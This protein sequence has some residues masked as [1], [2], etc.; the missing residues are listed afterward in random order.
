L[1]LLTGATGYV[2]GR[3]LQALEDSGRRVRCLVLPSQSLRS[4]LS[5]KAE[6]VTGD[7]LDA[8]SLRT[9]MQGV[10]T[11]YYLIYRAALDGPFEDDTRRAAVTFAAAARQ[12]GVRR[13]IYLGGLSGGGK[14][15][16][17]LCGSREIGAILRESG[18]VVIEFCTSVIV[19]SG[20]LSFEMIRTIVEKHPVMTTPRWTWTRTR[21]IAIEDVVAYLLA[22]LDTDIRESAIFEIGGADQVS[23]R[24]L[25]REYAHQRGLKRFLIP[26]P[27]LA[28]RL[29]IL[30]LSLVTPLY[31]RVG[32]E[33]VATLCKP[34]VLDNSR[35]LE[36]FPV[37]PYGYREAI[38]RALRNEGRPAAPTRWSDALNPLSGMPASEARFGPRIVDARSLHVPHP[39]A[40][41][42]Q[43]I[44]RI[45]GNT[46]WYYA[47]LLWRL[48]GLLD[49]MLGGVG[50]KRGRRDPEELCVGDTVDFWRVVAFERGRLLRL[51]AEMKVPGRAW[52]QFELEDNGRGSIIQQT[53]IFDP[54]GIPGLLYWYILSPAHGLIF[55]GMLRGIARAIPLRGDAQTARG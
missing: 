28:P 34:T 23:F 22:A 35:A 15:S 26:V 24:D 30:W 32:Q 12:A 19:G 51:A 5:S 38:G 52:L 54:V 4:N 40:L 46:G 53:A 55:P 3:L 47:N 44:E 7:V 17:Q 20:S 50:A 8:G 33:L 45:G 27:M 36:D 9:A 11:A 43:P 1:I 2:G 41:A 10:D 42:F 49:A 21:P 18:A 6:A 37:R 13:I 29:T 39:S 14:Y 25:L 48:R 31:A 16:G